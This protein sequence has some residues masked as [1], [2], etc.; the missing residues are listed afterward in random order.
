MSVPTPFSSI[1]GER[2]VITMTNSSVVPVYPTSLPDEGFN[3]RI[4]GVVTLI[5]AVVFL[6]FLLVATP[7]MIYRSRP[8]QPTFPLYGVRERQYKAANHA[9]E[10]SVALQRVHAL[11]SS[12]D[13]E[14][15]NEEHFENSL[16]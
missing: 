3:Y 14:R 7:L 15:K 5:F 1:I 2:S 6:A 9:D 13:M 4:M 16:V 10:E 11:M 12:S 8:S